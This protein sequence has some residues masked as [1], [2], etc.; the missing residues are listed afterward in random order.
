MWEEF[1]RSTA[2]LNTHGE[3]PWLVGALPRA[4]HSLAV[5][6]MVGETDIK[7]RSMKPDSSVTLQPL[8]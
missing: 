4:A 3:R 7:Q 2:L 1:M 5:R 8:L 6:V